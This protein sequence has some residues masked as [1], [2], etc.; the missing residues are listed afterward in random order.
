MPTFGGRD[1]PTLGGRVL[2][3]A[4]DPINEDPPSADEL[5]WSDKLRWYMQEKSPQET[6]AEQQ[7]RQH[8]MRVLPDLFKQ[9]VCSVCIDKGL[10]PEVAQ[11]AG[12]KVCLLYTSPSPR[13]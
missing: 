4:H 2:K 12:G 5:R 8:I 6:E 1:Y 10:A 7:V 11:R 3:P 9:W 13:D